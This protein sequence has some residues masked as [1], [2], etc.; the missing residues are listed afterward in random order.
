MQNNSKFT[1]DYK[2]KK[3]F[4]RG[5]GQ[6][7]EQGILRRIMA[8]LKVDLSIRHRSSDLLLSRFRLYTMQSVTFCDGII[9]RVVNSQ[10]L[11]QV[12]FTCQNPFHEGN[13]NNGG[14][15]T[16]SRKKLRGEI[17]EKF[18]GGGRSSTEY[19]YF[20]ETTDTCSVLSF[21]RYFAVIYTIYVHKFKPTQKCNRHWKEFI[22]GFIEI[23]I[24]VSQII[25][26][27]Y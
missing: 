20:D 9:C 3:V 5:R 12:K 1:Q 8:F 2:F 14:V 21:L 7:I 25:F 24:L 10:Q 19:S 23:K 11:W 4:M 26:I 13:C 27:K 18:T 17:N 6:G 15:W 16:S 22:P